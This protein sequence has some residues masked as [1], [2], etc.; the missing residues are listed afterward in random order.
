MNAK[1]LLQLVQ[2]DGYDYLW[3]KNK[4][5][6]EL[7]CLAEEV[8]SEEYQFENFLITQFNCQQISHLG[9]VHWGMILD[10][11]KQMQEE[12]EEC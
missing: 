11:L 1:E 10:K 7:Y 8:F 3:N 2:K 12:E 9:N 5:T 4:V 6:E